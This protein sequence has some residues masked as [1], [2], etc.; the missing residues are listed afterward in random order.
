M[1]DLTSGTAGVRDP[2]SRPSSDG[3]LTRR[4]GTRRQR[5]RWVQ[6]SGGRRSA[7]SNVSTDAPSWQ[8]Q[9]LVRGSSL[10]W[11][12]SSPVPWS[13]RRGQGTDPSGWWRYSWTQYRRRTTEWTVRPLPGHDCSRQTRGGL[14]HSRPKEIQRRR[15]SYE[16]R[17]SS[18][19]R[20]I[21]ASRQLHPWQKLQFLN[22]WWKRQ[23]TRHCWSCWCPK[24]RACMY[25]GRHDSRLKK[26]KFSAKNA[27]ANAHTGADVKIFR[28]GVGRC[29]VVKSAES[30]V[31]FQYSSSAVDISG[32]DEGEL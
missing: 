23:K 2:I 1:V 14:D 29:S 20:T 32:W 10:S 21:V 9:W 11:L 17:W 27:V 31:L 5:K 7:T 22:R 28:H 12:Q 16:Q 3:F 25:R 15:N 18:V 26:K 6:P 8:P 13:Y 19:C 30:V 4:S 24:H